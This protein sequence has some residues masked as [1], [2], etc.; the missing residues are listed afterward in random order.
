M[1]QQYFPSSFSF[2]VY[3]SIANLIFCEIGVFCANFGRQ[4]LGLIFFFAFWKSG[5]LYRAQYTLYRIQWTGYNVQR[6]LHRVKCTVYTIKKIEL[7]PSTIPFL[8]KEQGAWVEIIV[9]QNH[10][11]L[12]YGGWFTGAVLIQLLEEIKILRSFH[13]I[14]SIMN[15]DQSCTCSR[16]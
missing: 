3:S 13:I 15:Q 9:T 4:R 14:K 11:Q 1:K 6:T 5:T 16:C 10:K 2:D 8:T 12:G 7:E